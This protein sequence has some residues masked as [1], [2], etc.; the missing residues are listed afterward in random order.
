MTL[1]KILY[2]DNDKLI[3]DDTMFFVNPGPRKNLRKSVLN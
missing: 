2:V 1:N 3:I